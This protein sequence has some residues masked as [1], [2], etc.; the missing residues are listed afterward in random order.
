MLDCVTGGKPYLLYLN[1]ADFPQALHTTKHSLLQTDTDQ[2][3]KHADRRTM[4]SGKACL[5][6]VLCSLIILS[7]F[8]GSTETGESN[9]Y[10]WNTEGFVSDL[11]HLGRE[12]LYFV[13]YND[14]FP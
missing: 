8:I 4:A 6:G 10:D 3:R 11:L 7:S 9:G 14:I 2:Q 13:F 1:L 5:L 12:K